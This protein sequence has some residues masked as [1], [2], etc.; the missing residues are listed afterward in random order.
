M[1]LMPSNCLQASAKSQQRLLSSVQLQRMVQQRST[2]DDFC[3]TVRGVAA[4]ADGQE[5]GLSDLPCG[6]AKGLHAKLHMGQGP[7][8]HLSQ[9]LGVT[10]WT[11]PFW[12]STK[13]TDK[14]WQAEVLSCVQFFDPKDKQI[15]HT[16]VA[17]LGEREACLLQAMEIVRS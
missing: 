10:G 13:A 15:F 1:S 16:L 6:A 8:Q 14:H 2:D 4:P 11:L 3:I 7:Q 17:G 12:L 9:K 5:L